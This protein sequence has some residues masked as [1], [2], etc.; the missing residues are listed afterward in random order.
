MAKKHVFVVENDDRLDRAVAAADVGI[1]RRRARVLIAAG[2]VFVDGQRCRVASRQMMA[3]TRVV[4]H[5]EAELARAEA[6]SILWQSADLVALAKPPGLHV[7]ETETS[8]RASVVSSWPGDLYVVH[9]LDRDTSGVL[10]A[11]RTASAAAAAAR[12]FERRQIE[13]TYWTVTV[14]VPAQ[15]HIDAPLGADRRR[16]RARAGRADGQGKASQTELRVLGEHA[17][18]AGVEAKPRTG[19]THQ[20]RVHLAYVGCPIAGDLLYGGPAASRLNGEVV[21]WPR[22]MLHAASLAFEWEGQRICI[23]APPPEDFGGL[24]VL[25]L[26][27]SSPPRSL[28]S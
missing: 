26:P 20:I 12:L 8:A 1:S 3:G 17:G 11:A 16:P 9:R 23:N 13:K 2:S 18:L 15:T 24:D 4:V 28:T 7:N 21:R 25:G 27:G 10:L 6:P 22:Y 14:G 5:A 19:R